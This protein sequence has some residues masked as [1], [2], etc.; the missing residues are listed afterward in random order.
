MKQRLLSFLSTLAL[1]A[2]AGTASALTV[3]IE[4]AGETSFNPGL[5]GS[6]SYSGT[7][8][9]SSDDASHVGAG[10][11]TDVFTAIDFQVSGAAIKQTAPDATGNALTQVS[12]NGGTTDAWLSTYSGSFDSSGVGGIEVASVGLEIRSA[13]TL[14]IFTTIDA[15]F[16]ELSDGESFGLDD[17][18]YIS[19]TVSYLDTSQGPTI[20]RKNTFDSF[21]ITVS[22]P[23]AVPLPAGLPLVLTGIGAF[24]VAR[25]RKG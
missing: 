21:S 1:V 25:R 12:I 22:D 14:E 24:A 2:A 18:G 5:P 15:L 23:S 10:Q 20:L 4:F 7:I 16:S 9:Y 17:V 13:A 3:T 6:G 19:L 11:F 8:Q